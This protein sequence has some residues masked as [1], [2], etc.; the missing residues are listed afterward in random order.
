MAP[1]ITIMAL[2]SR[3][4]VQPYL[5]LARGFQ[6]AGFHVRLA[7]ASSYEPFVT[8]Y[9]VEFHQLADMDV[10]ALARSDEARAMLDTKNPLKM[11]RSVFALMRPLY[12]E[13]I[14]GMQSALDGAAVGILNPLTQYGG[15]DVCENGISTV[16]SYRAIGD[17][18]EGT[19]QRICAAHPQCARAF[20]LQPAHTPDHD[21][22]GLAVVPS[23]GQRC[24]RQPVGL[25]EDPLLGHLAHHYAAE[26][27]GDV[28]LQ[29]APDS[30][31]GRLERLDPCAGLLV[32]Q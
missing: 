6:A 12:Y 23:T 17:S 2:G 14:D 22:D 25:G 7:T 5:A 24:A 3:G 18:D 4:Q 16:F 15:Y 26:N 21:P 10:Q 31:F 11:L 19:A 28:G 32:P 1:I 20:A 27:A 29:P 13:A 9:G 30:S 8:Q